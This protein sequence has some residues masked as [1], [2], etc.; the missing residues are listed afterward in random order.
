ME[1]G[2]HRLHTQPTADHQLIRPANSPAESLSE[3]GQ[4]LAKVLFLPVTEQRRNMAG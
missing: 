4:G 1:S 2:A 3:T